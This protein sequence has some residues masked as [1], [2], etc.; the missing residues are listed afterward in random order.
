MLHDEIHTD[1]I[2]RE[3]QKAMHD[4][5]LL[6]S[7]LPIVYKN[8]SHPPLKAL[9]LKLMDA[10]KRHQEVLDTAILSVPSYDKPEIAAES[11]IAILINSVAKDEGVQYEAS[12]V[13][14]LQKIIYQQTA[15]FKILHSLASP[16]EL[17]QL[18]E[19]FRHIV[20]ESTRLLEE[21][22]KVW[23]LALASTSH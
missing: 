12:I 13:S 11:M 16:F 6:E 21:L 22:K 19:D 20:D 2:K 7:F 14:T 23:T 9:T 18:S 15:N 5:G 17:Q 1:L 10:N 8:V 3:L 4:E